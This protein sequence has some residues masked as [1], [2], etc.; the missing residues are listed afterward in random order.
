MPKVMKDT[1]GRPYAELS[2]MKVGV[3][4]QVDSGFDCIKANS[5]RRVLRDG[6]G[7]E[8]LYIKCKSGKHFLSG[9]ADDGKHLIGLYQVQS[10]QPGLSGP[11]RSTTK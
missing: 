8:G 6:S 10:H 2:K 5:I 11:F 1:K 7:P 3:S 9:Q 4:L